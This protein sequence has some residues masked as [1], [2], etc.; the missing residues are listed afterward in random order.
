MSTHFQAPRRLRLNEDALAQKIRW[1]GGL[2]ATLEYG[3][4]PEDIENP[5]LA[6]L[7]ERMGRAFRDLAPL[8]EEV[9]A[10]LDVAH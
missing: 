4:A 6:D 9:Q 3:I 10:R 1:E 7:W 2:W 5:Q 8:F